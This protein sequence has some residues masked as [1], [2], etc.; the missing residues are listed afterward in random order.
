MKRWFWKVWALGASVAVLVPAAIFAKLHVSTWGVDETS[1]AA[2]MD[3]FTA[4]VDGF[5]LLGAVVPIS[6]YVLAVCV[7]AAI[8]RAALRRRTVPE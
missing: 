3:W 8:V 2:K 1:Y 7:V 4:N 5:R 6:V